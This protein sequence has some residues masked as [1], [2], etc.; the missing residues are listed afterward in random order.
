[1]GW[2]I[3]L[4]IGACIVAYMEWQ[5]PNIKSP[6]HPYFGERNREEQKKRRQQ[7]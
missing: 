4:F 1:M 6:R 3:G 7:R 5:H 2:I